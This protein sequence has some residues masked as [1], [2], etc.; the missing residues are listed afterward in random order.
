MSATFVHIKKT[1]TAVSKK[2]AISATPILTRTVRIVAKSSNGEDIYWG[3]PTISIAGDLFCGVIAAG[4]SDSFS[5][6][7]DKNHGRQFLDLSEIYIEV[8]SGAAS[9]VASITYVEE[10]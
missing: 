3:G 8:S 10:G 6:D 4:K 9:P 2:Q 1:L 7:A 5:V